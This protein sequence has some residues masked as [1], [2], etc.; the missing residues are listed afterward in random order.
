V[1]SDFT[2]VIRVRQHFGDD[3]DSLFG[4][5]AGKN[6][7]YPFPCHN[8]DSRKEAVLLFQSLDV[9]HDRNF[10]AINSTGATG[11]PE[12]YGG[13]PVSTSDR[14][15]NGNV[16]LIRSGVLREDNIL[17][18]GARA[19]N[20]GLGGLD[21]DVDEFIIDNVVVLFKTRPSPIRAVLDMLRVRIRRRTSPTDSPD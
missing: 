1:G 6:A 9:D 19:S 7:A 3:P 13:I 15:W 11:E 16:M 20:G 4:E 12:V 2:V 10:I 17:R 14:D 5:F 8:V 18:L 21:G